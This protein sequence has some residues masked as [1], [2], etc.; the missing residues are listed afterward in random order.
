MRQL[1]LSIVIGVTTL[2]TMGYAQQPSTPQE[3]GTYWVQKITKVGSEGGFDYVYADSDGRRL[4]IPR[5][6]PSPRVNVFNLD[7]LE[8][9]GEFPK[10]NA[11]GAATDSKSHHGFSSSSPVAMWDT[12][13]LA[14]V[15]TIPI[16][17]RPDGILAD[18]FNHRIYVLSHS[19]P[20][21]TVLDASDGAVLGTIDLGGAPE[22]AVSDGKGHIYIDLE[23]KDSVAVVDANTMKVSATYSLNGK[24]GGNAGLAL[25]VKNHVVFVA[26]REP[27]V[28][29]MLDATTGKYLADLPIGR[30]C[31]GAVFNPK[32]GECFSSQGDGT[33]T[34]IKEKSRTSFVVEQT[35]KTMPGAK[36]LTLDSKTGKILLIAAEYS[37][38]T[39][40]NTGGGRPGRGTLVPGSFSIITVGK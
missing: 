11:R 20:N 33:L 19:A 17:G 16:E 12:K 21:V 15:K 22:Q 23:D 6:G 34:I 27:Q 7:T 4:Y 26:C 9:A 3:G 18:A 38:P 24:G 39:A 1:L 37:A 10:T 40:P 13:T 30:G 5:S 29:V 32:T 36:T 31:D 28:M 14:I 2:S 25:D 35:V 8:P